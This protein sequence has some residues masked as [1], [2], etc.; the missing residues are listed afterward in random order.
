M[1]TM[2]VQ[3]PGKSKQDYKTPLEFIRAIEDRFHEELAWDLAADESNWICENY[4]SPEQDSFTIDWHKLID[5]STGGGGLL[6]LNP[7]FG[8]IAPWAEKCWRESKLGA[9][10]MLLTPAS[11]GANW[12]SFIFGHAY[13]MYLNPRLSFDGIASFPKDLMLSYFCHGIQ[14]SEIWEWK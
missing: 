14:G 10:I 5:P 3:K 11:V 13:V 8:K 1:S 12:F 7:P 9:R 2:P 4:I 6:W